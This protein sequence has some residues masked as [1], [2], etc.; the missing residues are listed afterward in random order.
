MKRIDGELEYFR[1]A[2]NSPEKRKRLRVTQSVYKTPPEKD[3]VTII[4]EKITDLEL[5]RLNLQGLEKVSLSVNN[6]ENILSIVKSPDFVK[7]I[8]REN[9]RF[10]RRDR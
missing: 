1:E 9:G 5:A 4:E 10:C 8:K 6:R 3:V 7:Q 2:I